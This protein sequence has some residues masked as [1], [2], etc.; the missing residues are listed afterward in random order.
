MNPLV[1]SIPPSLIR[2]INARK[3]AGD[4]DL[5]LG[6]PTL[7]PDAAPFRAA[8]EWVAEHGC[9]YTGNAGYEELREMIARRYG[10]SRFPGAAGVCVTVG[11]EEALYL[12]IK[13]LLDPA[14]DEVLIVEPCYLAYPK[15]CAMEGVAHRMV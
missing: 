4:I 11:S 7:R 3:R 13:A 9:P 6:E 1:T 10:G 2:A 5:G 14:R 12:A 15:I 8:A